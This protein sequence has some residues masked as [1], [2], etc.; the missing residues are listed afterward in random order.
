MNDLS[1]SILAASFLGPTHLIPFF[2][3]SFTI[4]FPNGLSGPIT[5]ISIPFSLAYLA[6]FSIS[7]SEPCLKFAIFE[8]PG[9]IFPVI[10]HHFSMHY[11]WRV[12]LLQFRQLRPSSSFNLHYFFSYYVYKFK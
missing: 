12:L 10:Q 1:V 8:I 3:S 7:S 2:S 11:K 5:A 9:F 4:P 6:T